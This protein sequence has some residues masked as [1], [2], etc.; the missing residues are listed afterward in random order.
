ML[1][2]AYLNLLACK[3]LRA[4]VYY[5]FCSRSV[6]LRR[7]YFSFINK[8][9]VHSYVRII[10]RLKVSYLRE[11]YFYCSKSIYKGTFPQNFYFQ[12]L[13]NSIFKLS[14]RHIKLFFPNP[15]RL[16]INFVLIP[17]NDIRTSNLI[18][19]SVKILC[20]QTIIGTIFAECSIKTTFNTI[21][22]LHT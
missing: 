1:S 8:F 4:N 22:V 6:F 7:A 21:I 15:I 17:A 19:V 11:R 3:T 9:S 2:E 12:M 10:G 14:L 16:L 20:T 18:Q 13:I 5:C